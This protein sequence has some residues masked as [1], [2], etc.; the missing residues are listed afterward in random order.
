MPP[1]IY[2]LTQQ[3]NQYYVLYG[4]IDGTTAKLPDGVTTN[5]TPTYI[6]NATGTVQVLDPSG[7]PLV[8]GPGNLTTAPAT[9]IAASNGNYQFLITSVFNPPVKP[10]YRIIVDLTAAGGFIG[11]W[12][13]DAVVKVR[14]TLAP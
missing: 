11:H 6:N 14:K 12:E 10:G 4:L 2:T 13:F 7:T 3:N 1:T 8:I 9:Y 5:P